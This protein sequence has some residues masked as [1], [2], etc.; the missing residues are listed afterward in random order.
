[1]NMQIEQ[2]NFILHQKFSRKLYPPP[3]DYANSGMDPIDCAKN[4]LKQVTFFYM[5]TGTFL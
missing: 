5:I 3:T 1:M 4:K 2:Q